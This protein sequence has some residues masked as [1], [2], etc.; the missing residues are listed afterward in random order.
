MHLRSGKQLDPKHNWM[1][2]SVRLLHKQSNQPFNCFYKDK[3]FSCELPAVSTAGFY[4]GNHP[5]YAIKK[6]DSVIQENRK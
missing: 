2:L 6:N 4:L 5:P 3:S 1:S